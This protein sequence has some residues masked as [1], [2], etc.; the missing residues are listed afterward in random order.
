MRRIAVTRSLQAYLGHK[1]IQRTV[2]YF[3][4]D[5]TLVAARE[6]LVGARGLRFAQIYAQLNERTVWDQRTAH[7]N[8]TAFSAVAP[9]E[10]PVFAV[11]RSIFGSGIPQ[12]RIATQHSTLYDLWMHNTKW[13]NKS[14]AGAGLED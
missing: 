11:H 12:A 9:S 10:R 8:G 14:P 3:G 1:N 2:R 5:E 4:D 6:P 13:G 7:G